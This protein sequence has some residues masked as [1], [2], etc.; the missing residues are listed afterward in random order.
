MPSGDPRKRTSALRSSTLSTFQ[1]DSCDMDMT[2]RCE[3]NLKSRHA[4]G[5]FASGLDTMTI[6]TVGVGFST[7]HMIG[8]SSCIS[9]MTSLSAT[10]TFGVSAIVA[11]FM[12]AEVLVQ[13]GG[14]THFQLLL[15]NSG[16]CRKV[17][18]LSVCAMITGA[19]CPRFLQSIV[20]EVGFSQLDLG[21]QKPR[22]L[23]LARCSG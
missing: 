15:K 16:S 12:V 5:D 14:E 20:C 3:N 19:R 4:T 6:A 9:L 10:S 22:I 18:S 2:T 1:R 23:H 13:L 21:R 8:M 17:G 7:P 11:S